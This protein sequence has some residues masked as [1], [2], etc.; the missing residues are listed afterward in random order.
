M[1]QF[2]MMYP[3]GRR[4]ALR[5]L[6]VDTKVAPDYFSSNDLA[7]DDLW[8]EIRRAFE[9]GH[10][11]AAHMGPECFTCSHARFN[12]PRLPR[13][14]RSVEFP[15]GLPKTWP[16]LASSYPATIIAAMSPLLLYAIW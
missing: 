10:L 11:F 16:P 15:M 6:A 3:H 14:I 5:S 9:D 1:S 4:H 12:P 2:Y 8:L 7:S 13:P